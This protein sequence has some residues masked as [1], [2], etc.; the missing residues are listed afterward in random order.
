MF[1]DTSPHTL[2]CYR[3]LQTRI[4]GKI[5]VGYTSKLEANSISTKLILAEICH[6]ISISSST[7][8]KL[9]G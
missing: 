7:L 6:G 5:T 4:M 2:P 1:W 8:S 9:R 3:R